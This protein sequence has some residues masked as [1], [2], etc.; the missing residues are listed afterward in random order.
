MPLTDDIANFGPYE[1]VGNLD[2]TAPKKFLDGWYGFGVGNVWTAPS[3]GELVFEFELLKYGKL[4]YRLPF[5][6]PVTDPRPPYSA[7]GL[8]G[9]TPTYFM[10]NMT[11]G[12]LA[13]YEEPVT[14]N[15]FY[16]VYHSEAWGMSAALTKP[17][18]PTIKPKKLFDLN[19]DLKVYLNSLL[20]K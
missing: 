9:P 8:T 18:D 12:L 13:Q 15:P 14:E 16:I 5:N 4:I 17:F 11:S 6:I 1:V 20:N 7:L 10:L 2:V 19:A 3:Q